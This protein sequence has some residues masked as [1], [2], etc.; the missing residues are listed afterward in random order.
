M[1]DRR[2]AEIGLLDDGETAFVEMAAASGLSCV[3]PEA[4]DPRRATSRGTGEL[5]AAAYET[6]RRRIAVGLGG[7]A[8]NDGGAGLLA[9]LGARFL[10]AA[11]TERL[12]EAVSFSQDERLARRYNK[13]R[14]FG[15]WG[16]AT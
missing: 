15:R 8:T 2:Q 1:G 7:S 12:A 4:R 9:A 6:G 13:L 3:A 14:E 11:L 5:L 10:D 16:T